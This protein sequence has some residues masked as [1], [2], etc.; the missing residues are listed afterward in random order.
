MARCKGQNIFCLSF[1][2]IYNLKFK[3]QVLMQTLK[4]NI[5]H[6]FGSI[7]NSNE[8]LPAFDFLYETLPFSIF[9][10][11]WLYYLVMLD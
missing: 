11:F 8:L 6:R 10:N 7:E 2:K 4:N 1:N 3:L 9:D 5:P